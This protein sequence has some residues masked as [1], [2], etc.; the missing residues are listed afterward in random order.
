MDWGLT[1]GW[2][3]IDWGGWLYTSII[4]C[5]IYII[6]II[7]DTDTIITITIINILRLIV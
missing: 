1:E 3:E 5:L 6:I 4:V 7:A 2:L